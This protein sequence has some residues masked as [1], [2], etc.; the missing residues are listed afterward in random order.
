MKKFIT[1]S[2][3]MAL[4]TGAFAQQIHYDFA[5]TVESGQT[6][7][8]LKIAPLEVWVTYPCCR[9][10]YANGDHITTFYYGYEKPV[11]DLVIPPTVTHNDTVYTVTQIDFSAFYKCTDITSVVFPNTLTT[12]GQ[13]A[14][15][16]CRGIT[17]KVVI[18]D[19]VTIIGVNAFFY[20]DGITS[21]VFGSELKEI[22]DYSFAECHSL[23]H[24]S[25]LPE[26]LTVLDDGAFSGCYHLRDS[27]IIP[28]RV[29]TI[30]EDAFYYCPIPS[31][32]IS[33]GV[34]TIERRAF[35][36]CPIKELHIPSSLVS[37]SPED[38]SF[39]EGAFYNCS[40]LQSITVDEANPVYDSRGNC[41]ALIETATNTLLKGSNNTVIPN[42][43]T[44]IG[45]NAFLSINALKAINIPKS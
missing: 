37:I 7:Y 45:R 5:E 43:I 12:I 39:G 42:D 6:L 8:F 19:S 24:I 14:F 38:N 33:E 4:A 17:G 21:V 2:V 29:T 34:T 16:H 27:I 28:P 25:T 1:I 35:S 15:L 22:R 44:I 23:E 11:G 36:N 41:N 13:R 10:Y 20:C 3:I 9:D 26:S 31:V 32:V 30:G 18:P 40:K